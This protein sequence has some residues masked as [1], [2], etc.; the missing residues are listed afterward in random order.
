[1][2]PAQL[3]LALELRPKLPLRFG[4]LL[5]AQNMCTENDLTECLAEQFNMPVVDLETLKPK[6]KARQLVSGSFALNR[7]VLP[8]E[9]KDGKL[10]CVISDPIDI[11]T[12]DEL[13]N[14]AG[15][16][17]NLVLAAATPL[18]EAI[19]KAY[20]L[21]STKIDPNPTHLHIDLQDD[22]RALI[23]AL[24]DGGLVA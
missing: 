22:R 2:T 20:R 10:T 21:P 15:Y 8:I 13:R 14:R 19:R 11:Q 16:P 18:R 7:L 1:M 6:V 17:L 4:E 5:V 3:E 23:R 12:T 9:I 24:Q